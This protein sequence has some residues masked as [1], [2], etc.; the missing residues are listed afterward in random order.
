MVMEE[1]SF[2]IC[3]GWYFEDVLHIGF[4]VAQCIVL[5]FGTNADD[6][7]EFLALLTLHL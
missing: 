7:G 2:C 6:D 3:Y 4:A 1:V 5:D